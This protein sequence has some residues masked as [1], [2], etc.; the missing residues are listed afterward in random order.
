MRVEP[1][2]NMLLSYSDFAFDRNRYSIKLKNSSLD[3]FLGGFPLDANLITITGSPNSGKSTFMKALLF[4]IAVKQQ[5]PCLFMSGRKPIH[6]EIDAFLAGAMDMSFKEMRKIERI[7]DYESR[8]N[9]AYGEL[10]TSPLYYCHL[11]E[12]NNDIVLVEEVIREEVQRDNIKVIFIDGF[13]E[14]VKHDTSGLDF[15]KAYQNKAIDLV[16]ISQSINIPI[17]LTSRMNWHHYERMIEVN[18]PFLSDLSEIGDLNEFSNLV[19]GLYRP[20][21][22]RIF[23]SEKGYDLRG[24][25]EISVLKNDIGVCKRAYF[26]T[27]DGLFNYRITDVTDTFSMEV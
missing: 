26:E 2:K 24:L 19:I 20:E 13:D 27:R 1:I 21:L 5:I 23:E 12:S 18:R 17:V 22:D 25:T 9:K 3:M 11:T 10:N 7:P 15:R 6:W 14:I 16:R 4:D 8:L